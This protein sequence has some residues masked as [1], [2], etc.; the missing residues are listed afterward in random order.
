MYVLHSFDIW[1]PVRLCFCGALIMKT[2]ICYDEWH[3]CTVWSN[4]A[5]HA[6]PCFSTPIWCTCEISL[7]MWGFS[8][9]SIVI[10][11]QPD[12][13]DLTRQESLFNPHVPIAISCV[14]KLKSTFPLSFMEMIQQQKCYESSL[15]T[16]EDW[17]SLWSKWAPTVFRRWLNSLL[18]HKC[19]P[20]ICSPES[21][22]V[23]IW[24][25]RVSSQKHNHQRD[26]ETGHTPQDSVS[27][28]S[29]S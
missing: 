20:F 26:Q 15:R 14:N 6:C 7:H 12:Q 11:C 22:W 3:G 28:S 19:G 4:V 23:H 10:G 25:W 21:L 27:L 1:L 5:I 9:I 16:A 24:F 17:T 18:C 2:N 8:N 29:L 13:R